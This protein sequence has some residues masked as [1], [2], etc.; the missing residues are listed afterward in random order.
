MVYILTFSGQSIRMVNFIFTIRIPLTSKDT[1]RGLPTAYP[2]KA[3][4]SNGLAD[5]SL[6]LVHQ[7]TTIDPE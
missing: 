6:A 2:I 5:N 1:F 7:L 3:N 4:P